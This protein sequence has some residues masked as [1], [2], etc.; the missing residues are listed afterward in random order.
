MKT[1][2]N[3]D[4]YLRK[5]EHIFSNAKGDFSNFEN[6][7]ADGWVEEEDEPKFNR[8]RILLLCRLR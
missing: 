1:N 8:K 7:G 2:F 3:I 5:S 4:D 6:Y